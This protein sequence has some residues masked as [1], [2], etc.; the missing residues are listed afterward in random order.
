MTL[1]QLKYVHAVATERHFGRAAA[2]CRVAQP[3]LSMQ[4]KKLERELGAVLFDRS[5]QPIELTEVGRQVQVS[6]QR[7]LDELNGLSEWMAGAT[8]AIG[9]ALR[10]AVLPTLAPTL[11]PRLM[12]ALLKHYPD[13]EVNVL[14]RT[15]ADMV[16]DLKQG[17]IDMGIL[18]TP[19]TEPTLRFEATFMEPMYAYLHPDHPSAGISS[20]QLHPSDLPIETMLLLE[21]GHCFRAQVLQLCGMPERGAEVG[22]KCESGSIET[23][24]RLVRQSGGGTL[25]PGLEALEI[26][27]DPG[28][29][30]FAEPEPAREVSIAVRQNDHREALIH[31]MKIALRSVVPSS[32]QTSPIYRRIPWVVEKV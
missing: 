3:T 7:I 30:Q 26:H 12:P 8:E 16:K 27:H 13:L 14:E 9:G 24:K 5:T 23:L 1:Q 18:V 20:G 17:D 15:T 2:R 32:Y 28:L 19:L 21:E 11:L 22:F 10:L 31:G 29:R 6:A 4:L 25:I